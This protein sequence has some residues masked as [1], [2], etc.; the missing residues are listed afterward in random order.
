MLGGREGSAV[1]LDAR[2]PSLWTSV[3]DR[4]WLVPVRLQLMC[5]GSS[6]RPCGMS[7]RHTARACRWRSLGR[8]A[9]RDRDLKLRGVGFLEEGT[10]VGH[11]APPRSSPRALL[12][13]IS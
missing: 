7:V 8:G 1:A 11:L 2:Q 5:S 6:P 13:A 3:V 12:V 4:V 10:I 9:K